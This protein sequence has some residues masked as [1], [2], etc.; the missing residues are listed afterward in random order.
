MGADDSGTLPTPS[1]LAELQRGAGN[2]AVS[3]LLGQRTVAGS[4]GG[5]G[6]VTVQR[7][8]AS[9]HEW[10]GNAG[11]GAR[12]CR[13][14]SG[15]SLTFGEMVAMAGRPLLVDRPDARL[16]PEQ[17]AGTS[18]VDELEYVRRV[19]IHGEDT[20]EDFKALSD[21]RRNNSRTTGRYV[22]TSPQP[23]RRPAGPPQEG[24]QGGSG[25]A[26]ALLRARRLE[27]VALPPAEGRPVAARR[28]GSRPR[29]SPN[30]SL[31]LGIPA[32]TSSSAR[33][34]TTAI[35]T[36]GP[37]RRRCSTGQ[38]GGD[39]RVRRWRWRPSAPTT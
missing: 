10:L 28:P 24:R 9:E 11:S 4:A 32:G 38:T 5:M 34:P 14:A 6:A 7:F 21:V 30:F 23:A 2:H 29:R 39:D 33:P 15:Y 35:T 37:S 17:G 12:R 36:C 31:S 27:P 22:P 16:R 19:D 13:S 18:G 20:P 3:Q 1:G 8:N 25:G 26:E